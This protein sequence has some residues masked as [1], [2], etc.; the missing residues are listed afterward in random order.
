[1]PNN[2]SADLQLD[3]ILDSA[4]TAFKEILTPLA[5]FSTV[6]KDVPLQGT[7]KVIVPYYPLDTQAAKDFVPANGYEFDQDTNTATRELTINKRKYKPISFTSTEWNR[8]PMLDW[9][10]LGRMA[11]MKLAEDVLV[12]I[13][14][15]IT[16]A[17]YGVPVFT[18]AAADF[19]VDDVIDIRTACDQAKWPQGNRS[20]I[21][22]PTYM[23]GLTKDMNA[24]GGIATYERDPNGG[25]LT[26]PTIGGFSFAQSNI[27]PANAEN[28][29]GMVL[30][31]S[32]I[33][34]GFS[35]IEPTPEVRQQLNTYR[36]VS[37]PDS[38]ISLEYREWGDPDMDTAKRTIEVN[39]GFNFGEQAAL[40]RMTSA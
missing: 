6:F 24:N 11:G 31:E 36:V 3:V 29:I 12:D 35:P 25:I 37:D 1:M 19:D 40:K 26:F 39:Y 5:M 8:Q 17:N 10:K 22:D 4:M 20:M 34:V 9:E 15:I 23:G 30:Y 38:Q 13:W 33:L 14:S 32:A 18:G 21:V 27:I 2:I 7:D 16:A 28:L